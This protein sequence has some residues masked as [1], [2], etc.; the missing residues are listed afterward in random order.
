MAMRFMT[1]VGLVAMAGMVCCGV[2]VARSPQQAGQAGQTATEQQAPGSVEGRV[3]QEPGGQPIRKVVVR[4]LNAEEGFGRIAGAGPGS[5]MEMMEIVLSEEERGGVKGSQEYTTATDATGQFKFENVKPGRY[6]VWLSRSGYVM[7]GE[8][9]RDVVITVQ[10][11]QNLSGLTYKMQAG[12]AIAGKIVDT[13][14]DALPHVIVQAKRR[15]ASTWLVGLEAIARMTA[16]TNDLGEYRIG[17]L[18]AGQYIV[19]AR[20]Q[21]KVGPPPNPGDKGQSSERVLYVITYYPGTLDEKGANALQVTPGGTATANFTLLTNRAYRVSGTVAGMTSAKSGAILLG[22]ANGVTQQQELAEGGKFD[23][24]SVPAGTYI[25]EVIEMP[26]GAGEGQ[27]RFMRIPT[28]IV[29]SGSDQTELVLQPAVS[30]TVSGKFIVTDNEKVDWRQMNV[31]L[32]PMPEEGEGPENKGLFGYAMAGGSATMKEDGTFEV[33]NVQAGNYQVAVGTQA[34]KYKDWYLK[35]VLLSGRDVVDTGF[36]VNGDTDV[37][38][39]VS[40]KGASVEGTVVDSTGQPV[41]GVFVVSLPSSGKLGR[42]DSYQRERTS[43]NGH[44]LLRGMNPGEFVVVA[45]DEMSMDTRNAEFFQKYAGK[46]TKVSLEEGEKK[47][48]AVTLVGE[49]EKK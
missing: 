29:V 33:G 19:E 24:T 20:T 18:R 15:K 6:L 39:V 12:G 44:F 45:S 40:A 31:S 35:A 23:F 25:A 7:S 5:E 49:E 1:Q 13:D 36:A 14:G 27:A 8:R 28:P 32:M 21:G 46:G 3:V 34:E 2:C 4:L 30:G 16:E 43:A 41:G 38:V 10:A 26:S 48:V 22:S 42:P 17:G 9:S 47:S 37:E 11:G